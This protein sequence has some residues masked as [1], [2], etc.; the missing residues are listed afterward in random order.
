MVT[1]L[2]NT[3]EN[4]TWESVSNTTSFF[5]NLCTIF[6]RNDR[7]RSATSAVD[8]KVYR[9]QQCHTA[10]A[11]STTPRN[12]K[13]Y[14][15][16]RQLSTTSDD[17]Y[18]HGDNKTENRHHQQPGDI[19]PPLGSILGT[20]TKLKPRRAGPGIRRPATTRLPHTD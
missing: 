4:L 8:Y 18:M 5:H 7:V 6:V 17:K 2:S 19:R 13:E 3:H 1:L 9:H 15:G 12:R 20:H 10:A 11:C 14:P 16:S